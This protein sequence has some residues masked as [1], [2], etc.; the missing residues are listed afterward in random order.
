M[1]WSLFSII[2]W[3][4]CELSLPTL[5]ADCFLCEDLALIENRVLDA[6]IAL[7]SVIRNQL[8]TLAAEEDQGTDIDKSEETHRKV[9]KCPGRLQGEESAE[10]HHC[11]GDGQK[12]QQR[13]EVR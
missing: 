6:F 2:N 11:K 12:G 3:R 10:Y 7:F 5:K 4:F 13:K 9:D 1:F 8:E